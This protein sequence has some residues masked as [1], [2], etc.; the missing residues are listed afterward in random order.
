MVLAARS[1]RRAHRGG[2]Q[3]VLR[4]LVHR[5]AARRDPAARRPGL[6]PRRAPD[7]RQR[8]PDPGVPPEAH[9]AQP[10]GVHGAGGGAGPGALVHHRPQ[11]LVPPHRH[12]PPG[13]PQGDG[14]RLRGRA[15]PQVAPGQD[16]DD[17]RRVH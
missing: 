10:H 1:E 8:D 6:L 15:R 4:R 17:D 7:A 2:H 3:R 12:L 14:R 11:P 13:A 16:H 5:V 9:Q